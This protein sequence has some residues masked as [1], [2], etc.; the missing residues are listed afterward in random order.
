MN[1]VDNLLRYDLRCVEE[2]IYLNER[3]LENADD[4][5]SKLFYKNEI[6]KLKQ[7]RVDLKAA[8]K[9]LNIK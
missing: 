5:N 9:I 4:E 2:D 6:K 8:M 1:H 7:C 3:Y